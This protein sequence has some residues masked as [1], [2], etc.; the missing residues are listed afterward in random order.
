MAAL[1]T[2]TPLAAALDEFLSS[3]DSED[4]ELLTIAAITGDSCGGEERLQVANFVE[5]V[6]KRF[7]ETEVKSAADGHCERKYTRK[8]KNEQNER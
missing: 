7:G 3:S 1:Q 6:V 2:Q 4:D 8:K 5:R